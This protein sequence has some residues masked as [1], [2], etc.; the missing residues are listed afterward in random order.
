MNQDKSGGESVDKAA[1][2]PVDTGADPNETHGRDRAGTGR[3]SPDQGKGT[4]QSVDKAAGR[5]VDTGADPNETH[6]RDRTGASHDRSGRGR[7][8]S[9]ADGGHLGPAGDPAEGSTDAV[10]SSQS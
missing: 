8:Q 2:R 6:G 10:K 1:G 4:E 9:L 3:G 5:P 7:E